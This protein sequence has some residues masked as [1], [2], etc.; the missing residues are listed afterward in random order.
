[1]W[2]YTV[3][4]ARTGYKIDASGERHIGNGKVENPQKTGVKYRRTP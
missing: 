3:L 2:H 1:M 4:Q